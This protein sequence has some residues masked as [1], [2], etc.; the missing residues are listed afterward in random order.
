[1]KPKAS[2]R[3]FCLELLAG[4]RPS[5]GLETALL[6]AEAGLVEP[7]GDDW[8]LTLAGEG[9]AEDEKER[10]RTV[11]IRRASSARARSSALR[12]LGLRR[13]PYGWE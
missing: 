4:R 11:A 8:V 10:R 1:M 2:V 6:A 13:T 3:E 7:K 12:S 5:W 9:V